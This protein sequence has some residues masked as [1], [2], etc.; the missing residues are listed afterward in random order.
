VST[1]HHVAVWIDHHEARVFF[2][3]KD[4]FDEATFRAPRHHV[5]R[6]PDR[7]AAEKSHPDD[8]KKF[9]HELARTLDSADEVLI[10]GPSTTKL[11]F[12]KYVHAHDPKLEPHIVGIETVDHPTDAQLAAYARQYFHDADRMRGLVP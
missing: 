6:H 3:E 1:N 8:E 7:N 12:L 5:K 2:V 4:K 9:F 11:H 10:V